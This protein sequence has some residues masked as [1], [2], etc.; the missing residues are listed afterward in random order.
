MTS[1]EFVINKIE[2][3]VLEFPFVQCTYQFDRFSNLHT[4]EVLPELYLNNPDGFSEI[5]YSIKREF[6]S[7]FPY[8]RMSFFTTGNLVEIEQENLVH[9]AKGKFYKKPRIELFPEYTL[10]IPNVDSTIDKDLDYS[11]AA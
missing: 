8:E 5:E 3:L 6:I 1:I 9:I 2:Q 11:I 4:V 10:H 7:K